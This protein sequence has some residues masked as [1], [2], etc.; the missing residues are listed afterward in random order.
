MQKIFTFVFLFV[1]LLGW[2]NSNANHMRG[3][4]IQYS[5]T[6]NDTLDVLVSVYKDCKGVSLSAIAMDLVGIGCNFNSSYTMAQVTCKDIT[7]VCKTSC[8]KCDKSNCNAHGYPNGSNASC[9]F[10]YGIE[11]LVFKQRVIFPKNTNCCKLRIEVSECCRAQSITTCCSGEKLYTF[12]EINRCQS[13]PNNSPAIINDPLAIVC[14]GNCVAMNMGAIDTIDGD[15]ITYHLA[16]AL[17]AFNSS[18]TYQGAYSYDR[19]F[20]YDGFPNIKQ[21]NPS[22]CKGIL[23]DSLTGDFFFKPMQQ[24]VT[25]YAIEL[26]EW[27]KDSNCKFQLIGK[28]RRDMS[29]FV[30]AN[31]TNKPPTFP[32]SVAHI[33]AGDKVC[34]DSIQSTDPDAKDIVQFTWNKGIPKG[35]FTTGFKSNANKQYFNFCWQT[36][37]ND[38]R[39]YPY[40]FTA[41]AEDDACPLVGRFTKSFSIN[42]YRKLD[43]TQFTYSITKLPCAGLKLAA[44]Y[45]GNYP[46]K[47]SYQWMVDSTIYY[48]A[49]VSLSKLSNGTHIIKLKI[50]S[51]NLFYVLIDT[52]YIIGNPVVDVGID[53]VTCYG[54]P[55]VLYANVKNGTLPFKY[56]WNTGNAADTLDSL[57]LNG[58]YSVFAV[59]KIT[60]SAGCVANDGAVVQSILKTSLNLG[61]DQYACAGDQ[62]TF[63]AP[64][65]MV[66]Y[67]W[68][69]VNTNSILTYSSSFTATSPLKVVCYITDSNGCSSNDTVSAFFNPPVLVDAGPDIN[70]CI[71]DSITLI[72][73]GKGVHI[74]K[75]NGSNTY[76]GDT[77]LFLPS[78]ANVIVKA[79]ETLNK[80]SCEN[81][82]TV[83]INL[84]PKPSFSVQNSYIVCKDDTAML[85]ANGSNTYKYLWSSGDSGNNIKT[86]IIGKYSITAT[87]N[88][89]CKQTHETELFNYPLSNIYLTFLNDTL[90][91]NTNQSTTN[92]KWYLNNQYYNTS[93][94]P[95]QYITKPGIYTVKISDTNGCTVISQ[96]YTVT[97]LHNYISTP[98]NI[99][100]FKIYPNPSTGI[101]YI[102][103]TSTINV[104]I[105]IGITIYDLMGRKVYNSSS[106][107][108][109]IDLSS[110]P[111]GIYLLQINKNIWVRLSKQ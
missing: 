9:A 26:R 64:T 32:D 33:Y 99:D 83:I 61:V 97:T 6:S 65:N 58:R 19:P 14:V 51:V 59:C 28:T 93:L 67:S 60:D 1:C 12:A 52:L 73:K 10:P 90:Y 86:N 43:S 17:N 78:S 20:Y 38:E 22:T 3:V 21:Y 66:A 55:V 77:L 100:E 63:N 105:A 39:P 25:Q 104:P 62:I 111:E 35:N 29:L 79:T 82:D 8:S 11:K 103:S 23:L 84:Y 2:H 54:D 30:V 40:I 36:D 87:N 45:S 44:K 108:N 34:F 110:Q 102:E 50:P 95:W 71:G 72:A 68:K 13:Q 48:S 46:C 70:L 57:K 74:W 42:I 109:I 96:P 98:Q 15:L 47:I 16:P 24:Q 69:D 85:Q 106:N 92:F 41:T 94:Y 18:C 31:C 37:S 75:Y 91:A 80:V 4:D 53:T 89:G 5:F 7:P 107:K 88:Y 76:T 81:T 101:Y 27:R 56:Q 49:T